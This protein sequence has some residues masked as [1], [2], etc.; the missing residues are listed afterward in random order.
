MIANGI[1]F[2][3]VD[4]LEQME[5][6]PGV[7]IERFPQE[8]SRK[9]GKDENHRGRSRAEKS[10]STELRFVTQARYFDLALTALN[11]DVEL[12]V[13]CGDMVHQRVMLK[14]G[15]FTVLHITESEIYNTVDRTM[16]PKGRFA[17]Y[18]WRILLGFDG[19]VQFHY[20]DTFGYDRRPPSEAEKPGK[21]LLAY[22]SSITCGHAVKRYP[23][24]YAYQTASR[25]GMD[26]VN[27]GLSGAC[28]I[29]PFVSDYLS[30]LD[31]DVVLAELGVNMI[32][33][34]PPEEFEERVDYFLKQMKERSRAEYI[35]VTDVF[36]N[37]GILALDKNSANH[38][39]YPVY[40]EIVKRLVTA[41]QDKRF[42]YLDGAD[43]VKD[44]TY[45]TTDLLH[46]SDEG[47]VKMAEN[48]AG[49]MEKAMNLQ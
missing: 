26:L 17:P 41:Q 15:V 43:I 19:Y 28:H 16:L 25:L 3:N 23:T 4:H 21:T 38:A 46:P 18:V 29:E 7:R 32:W 14:A 45:L 10:Q 36:P 47:H 33:M 30:G 5:G 48:L 31:A 24:C 6:V 9:L 11:E 22:G 12:T 39:R 35:F 49:M 8:F 2:H 40:K 42:F 13:Y 27:K 34:F 1:E 44:L 20:L 37:K